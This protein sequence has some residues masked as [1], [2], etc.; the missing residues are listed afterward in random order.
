MEICLY[1]GILIYVL[2]TIINRFIKRIPDFIAIPLYII[3]I[4]LIIIG[5]IYF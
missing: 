2:M 5:F 1:I 3:G 4:I